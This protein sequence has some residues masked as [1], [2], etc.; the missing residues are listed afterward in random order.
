MSINLTAS[1]RTAR[2]LTREETL[3]M[4]RLKYHLMSPNGGGRPNLEGRVT[5][6]RR[7]AGGGLGVWGK[8]GVRLCMVYVPGRV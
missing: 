1:R 5:D 7:V 8:G 4:I 3:V 2:R 6:S